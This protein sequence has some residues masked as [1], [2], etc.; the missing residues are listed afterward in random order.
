MSKIKFLTVLAALTLCQSAFGQMKGWEVGG[1]LGG[2]NY[3]GDLNDNWRLRRVG[4]AAGAGARYNF[5]ER[6]ALRFGGSYGNIAA[7]DS[8]SRNIYQQR[9]NLSFKSVIVDVSANF[10]FN[11]LPYVHGDRDFFYTPYLFV[12]PSFYYFN[13]K[14][15]LDGEWHELREF[16]TEGQFKGEEYNTTQGAINFGFG[17]KY[18]LNY[19]WSLDLF[20]S[21]RKLFTDYLDDVSASYPDMDDLESQ[22]GDLAVALSDRSGEPKIGE[23]GRQRGNGKNNDA[24]AFI[25]LGINYYFGAI[26]CPGILR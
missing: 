9:R 4:L 19:R 22:R 8:D 24:F 23:A 11:F 10:E 21:G 26:R 20:I 5:N 12:G 17:F 25:G 18:D 3:F 6:L 15:K 7:Y 2:S 13:P 16:G 14:A 1:W